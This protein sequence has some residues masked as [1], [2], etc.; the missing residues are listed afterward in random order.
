LE[1][2]I[3]EGLLLHVLEVLIL[4]DLLSVMLILIDF[5]SFIISDLIK[6][7]DFMEVLILERLGR[8]KCTCAWI[9]AGKTPLLGAQAREGCRLGGGLFPRAMRA[10]TYATARFMRN[11]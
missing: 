8:A 4:G 11:S 1:V 7:E 5:K 2:L 9:W 10:D 3:L 6:N